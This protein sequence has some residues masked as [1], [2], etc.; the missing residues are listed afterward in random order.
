MKWKAKWLAPAEDMGSKVPLFRKHFPL[1]SRVKKAVLYITAL[2]VYEAR[3]NGARV[4]SFI[5][6][7]GWS[8]YPKRLQYQCY[9]V[10]EL[11]KETNDIHVLVGSGW[12]RGRMP[13]WGVPSPYM[14]A[15]RANPPAMLAQLE[16]TYEDGSS[17]IIV[18]D[19]SWT[20]S[21]NQVRFSDIY[22]GEICDASMDTFSEASVKVFDGPFHTLIPQEGG[23]IREQERIKAASLFVT[24]RGETVIDFGQNLTGY[25]EVSLDAKKGQVVDLSFAEVMDKEGNFYNGNKKSS[26]FN[27][28]IGEV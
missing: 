6:A 4:G 12:Y 27:A 5:L 1:P 23:E 18:S 21:E 7:P 20:V 28:F 8:A 10:S 22:D 17:E 2:G 25:V 9:D 14:D 26:I 19:E 11:L 24:P 3:I 15:L 13:G 16:I